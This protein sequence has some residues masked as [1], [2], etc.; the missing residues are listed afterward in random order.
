M[1]NNAT[2]RIAF[3]LSLSFHLLGISAGNMLSEGAFDL[4]KHEIEVTYLMLESHEELP[5][6]T[7]ME[8]LPQKYQLDE[9][10]TKIGSQETEKSAPRE[11]NAK[12]DQD[13]NERYLEKKELEELEEYIQYYTLVREKIKKYVTKNYTASREEGR[14]DLAFRLGRNGSLKNIRIDETKSTKNS[15]LRKIAT[16]SLEQA[17]PFPAFPD[18]L[19]KPELTFSITIIFKKNS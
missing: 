15:Y 6:E 16:K 2:F 7:T 14:I 9:M 13:D 8:K 5:K 1:W 10:E 12:K 11:V 17:S 4:K 19:S 18:K 3:L